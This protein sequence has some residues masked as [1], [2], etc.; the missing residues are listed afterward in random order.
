MKEA[1]LLSLVRLYP[2]STDQFC[3]DRFLMSGRKLYIP[4]FKGGRKDRQEPSSYRP[5]SLTSC[6]VR[7]MENLK[8][9][10]S[11]ILNFFKTN[12]FLYPLSSGFFPTHL[13]V[14]QLAYLVHKW[15]MTL[16]RG[17]SIESVFLDLSK[18]YDRVS[19]QE[20]IKVAP[21]QCAAQ[22]TVMSKWRR[23]LP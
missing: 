3:Y 22:R 2:C 21:A 14:T 13:T 1:G 9:V 5:I 19:H 6:V 10:N 23:R 11:K 17:E 18:A 20:L 8:I 12:A 4:I 15:L 7:T 16:D